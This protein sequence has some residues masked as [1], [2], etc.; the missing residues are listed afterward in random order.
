MD[1]LREILEGS[2]EVA[3]DAGLWQRFTLAEKENLIRYFRHEFADLSLLVEERGPANQ[4][5]DIG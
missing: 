3:R 2:I 5:A 4:G 1:S